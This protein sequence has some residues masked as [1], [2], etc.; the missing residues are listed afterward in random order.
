MADRESVGKKWIGNL[1]Y[2]EDLIGKAMRCVYEG[3]P[4]DAL[5]VGIAKDAIE[6]ADAIIARLDAEESK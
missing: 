5:F 1:T 2:R 6:L 4:D 3:A